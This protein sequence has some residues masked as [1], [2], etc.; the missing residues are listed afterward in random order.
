VSAETIILIRKEGLSQPPHSTLLTPPRSTLLVM[1]A[2]GRGAPSTATIPG[3]VLAD[4]VVRP[5]LSPSSP[6][7]R[8]SSPPLS[9]QLPSPLPLPTSS[10][11][12]APRAGTG[13]LPSHP[14]P[15]LPSPPIPSRHWS[16]SQA[17]LDARTAGQHGG[18]TCFSD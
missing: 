7:P 12:S 6:P 18:V 11:W 9:S 3:A 2:R 16:P 14:R 13:S 5:S 1:R 8:P 17:S 15:L 10:N 4:L